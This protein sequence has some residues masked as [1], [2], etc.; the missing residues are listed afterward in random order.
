MNILSISNLTKMGRENPLFTGV[1]FG[2]N[3]GE[4]AAII[5]RDGTGKSTLLSII[6]GKE[7]SDS[8]SVIFRRDIK[9][10]ILE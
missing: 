5:G 8:G 6:A 4:K 10:G 9:V 7:G 2:L 3:E 1:T